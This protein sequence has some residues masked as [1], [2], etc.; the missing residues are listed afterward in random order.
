MIFIF[1]LILLLAYF[2]ESF[3]FNLKLKDLNECEQVKPCN[4]NSICINMLGTFK[5]ECLKGFEKLFDSSNEC[6]GKIR[7]YLNSLLKLVF[8]KM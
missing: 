5:C 1:S 8:L 6:Y 4:E 3:N 7:I 2:V